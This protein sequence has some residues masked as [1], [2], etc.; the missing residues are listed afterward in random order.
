MDN[1]MEDVPPIGQQ[2]SA[3]G[4]ASLKKVRDAGK[5]YEA[6]QGYLASISF[7]DVLIGRFVDAINDSQYAD[8]TV[9]IF[10]SDNGFHVGEKEHWHK[11]TLWERATHV[12]FCIVAPGLTQPGGICRRPVSLQDV[13]PTLVELCGLTSQ[14]QLDGQSLVPLLAQPDRERERPAL[15]TYQRGNHA[16]RNERWRY[17]CYSDGTEELYDHESDPN[18]FHN[19]ADHSEYDSV[20]EEFAQWLPEANAPDAPAKNDYDFDYDAY[21]W[22]RKADSC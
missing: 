16:L 14:D 18:E 3:N 8:N 12:P 1:D 6:I 11:S 20:K 15:T 10:Y 13:Y 4:R 7:A 17:I 21:T 5:W 19:L 2:L 22:I 9:I